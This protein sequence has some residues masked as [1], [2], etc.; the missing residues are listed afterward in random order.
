MVVDLTDAVVL[1]GSHP[2]LAGVTLRVESGEIVLLQGPNG[3]GK[4]TV[5]RLCAGL[6]PLS[7]GHAE[8]LGH[9]VAFDRQAIR[10]R[11]GL[12]GHAN[13]LFLDLTARE[14]L[15][16]W[17]RMVGAS[18]AECDEAMARMGLD[19][20]AGRRVS[21]MSA[22]QRRRVALAGLVVRRAE[23]WLL[24]EPHTSLDERGRD[25]LDAVLRE[26]AAS[27]ATIVLASH[28]I[29]RAR[30]LSSRAVTVAGGRVLA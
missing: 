13:G 29:D 5:L 12:L 1:Y 26:A 25:E 10:R 21:T 27:G 24:D 7:R 30:R 22:G 23:L 11:V 19:A 17:G 9:D 14:N 4:S 18:V 8:I 20:L 28:E 3:A 15:D 16:F 2:A 6:V